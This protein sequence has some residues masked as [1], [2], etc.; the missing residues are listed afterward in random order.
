MFCLIL[1]DGRKEVEVSDQPLGKLKG[2]RVVSMALVVDLDYWEDEEEEEAHATMAREKGILRFH[3]LRSFSKRCPYDSVVLVG[4]ILL[5]QCDWIKRRKRRKMNR[6][7][8]LV[9]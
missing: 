2:L 8:F 5:F 3:S 9:I 6:L 4:M 1:F 7:L